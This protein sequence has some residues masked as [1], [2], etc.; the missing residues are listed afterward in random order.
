MIPC[1]GEKKII[2]EFFTYIE[3]HALKPF[4]HC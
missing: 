4:I 1:G 2:G 3:F